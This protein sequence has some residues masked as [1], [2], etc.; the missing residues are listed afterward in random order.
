MISIGLT[1]SIGMGKSTTAALFREEGATV[2][3]AD[4]AVR[5][6]YAADGAAVP[7]IA[8]LA[9]GAILDGAVD[10]TRLREAILAD[11]PLLKRVEAAVHP[12]VAA[13]RAAA[14]AQAE[15]AGARVAVFD[16]PLLFE[17]GGE[18]AFDL[19]VVVSAPEPMQRARVLARPGMTAAAFEA[20]LAKQTPDA[21]KRRR[22]DV[23]I[24]TGAGIEAAR[25]EVRALM[26]R[27][28]QE[29][30]DA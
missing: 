28:E 30:G 16:I 14:R 4:E 1:G 7:A 8:A 19:V 29:G 2:W 23:V 10:R 18:G 9:P 27:L 26:Q 15:A 24:D 21:E 13:D 22:A 25:A 3:D 17:T 5:R 11:P 20:I 6:L 12:L